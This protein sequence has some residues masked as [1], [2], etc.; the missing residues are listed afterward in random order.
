MK[1]KPVPL[2]QI[3]LF[4]LAGFIVFII[5]IFFIG[6]K[7]KLFDSTTYV[8]AK[9]ENVSGLKK[10]AQVQMAGMSVGNVADIRLPRRAGERVIV[11]LKIDNDAL[12]LIHL[13][14]RAEI[15]SEGL[16]GNK[17]V[18]ITPG[19]DSARAVTPRDT[20]IGE[21]PLELASIYDTLNTAVQ[22]VN[23][24]TEEAVLVLNSVRNGTGTIARLINDD[25]LHRDLEGL[26]LESRALASQAQLSVASTTNRINGLSDQ[27]STTITRINSGEGSIGKLLQDE[28][29]FASIKTSSDNL[30]LSSYDL[31]DALA[32]LALGSGRFAEVTEAMKHN[33]L[34]KGY[35]EDRGYWDAADF[36][37]AIDRKIDSLNRLQKRISASMD[38]AKEGANQALIDSLRR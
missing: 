26:V 38:H 33:F 2:F 22:R 10:G 23:N 21:K 30:A 25:A 7:S 11:R 19:T 15:S 29:V 24:L 17:I 20:L 35:F 9:F 28:S 1:R 5:F 4:V 36:E 37:R 8:F 14:S 34:V 32:K 18:E 16:I 31:R 12:P 27:L 13:D 6:S 3:G